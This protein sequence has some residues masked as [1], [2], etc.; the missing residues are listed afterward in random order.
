MGDGEWKVEN[1]EWVAD[2]TASST[3]AYFISDRPMASA[4]FLRSVRAPVRGKMTVLVRPDAK[5]FFQFK[6][7]Q[8][9]EVRNDA[10]IGEFELGM[11]EDPE[12]SSPVLETKLVRT[13]PAPPLVKMEHGS[14]VYSGD[15]KTHRR[16]QYWS[17]DYDEFGIWVRGNGSFGKVTLHLAGDHVGYNLTDIEYHS[18]VCHDGWQLLRTKLPPNMKDGK[19]H[20]FQIAT[21]T[22]YACRNALNPRDMRPVKGEIALGPV[23]GI[24]YGPGERS[25]DADVKIDDVMSE[26]DE[27]DL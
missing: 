15:P 27:K 8:P 5:T 11:V 21:I 22:V 4:K 13:E 12:W 9:H 17:D 2:V 19:N 14:F 25:F 20:P 7:K 3:P 10:Q 6:P 23:V 18:Y 26:I 24:K 16:E 1:G